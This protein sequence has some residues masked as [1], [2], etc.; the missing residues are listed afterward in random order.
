M[1]GWE[2][3]DVNLHGQ[4]S[5]NCPYL[6]GSYLYSQLLNN[7]TLQLMSAIKTGE[8][9]HTRLESIIQAQQKITVDRSGGGL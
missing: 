7:F 1:L 5:G 8:V 9:T 2:G 3:E 6:M 4:A